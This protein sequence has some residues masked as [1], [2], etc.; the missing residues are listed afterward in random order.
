MEQRHE[1]K[2]VRLHLT[3]LWSEAKTGKQET[4]KAERAN[5]NIL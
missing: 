1:K 4:L 2:T 5:I 3:A